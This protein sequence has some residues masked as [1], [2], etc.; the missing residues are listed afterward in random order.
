MHLNRD[1][2]GWFCFGLMVGLGV[3]MNIAQTGSETCY[4]CTRA[5]MV[6]MAVALWRFG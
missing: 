3:A 6:S 2:L 5:F 1:W 4:W